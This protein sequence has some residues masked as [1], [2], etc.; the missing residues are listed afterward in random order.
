MQ[1]LSKKTNEIAQ[2][3][4]YQV[5]LWKKKGNPQKNSLTGNFAK[6]LVLQLKD[7]QVR[8]CL[9]KLIMEKYKLNHHRQLVINN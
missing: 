6:G 4:H 5:W 8:S 2:G 1:E 9:Q 3:N 7:L